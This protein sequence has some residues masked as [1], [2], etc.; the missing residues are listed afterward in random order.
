MKEN[1]TSKLFVWLGIAAYTLAFIYFLIITSDIP[2]KYSTSEAIYVHI[3]LF[4]STALFLF[5]TLL[6]TKK[7]IRY[8]FIAGFSIFFILN[9]SL[10]TTHMSAEYFSSSFAQLSSAFVLSPLFILLTNV[11]LHAIKYPKFK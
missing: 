8:Y 2:V 5:G 9:L 11:F 3:I 10:F 1:S 6:I 7:H 4:V